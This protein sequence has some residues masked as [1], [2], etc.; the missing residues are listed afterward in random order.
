MLSVL[1]P[2][3]GTFFELL[4]NKFLTWI[5]SGGTKVDESR[6]LGVVVSGKFGYSGRLRAPAMHGVSSYNR[7]YSAMN[8]TYQMTPSITIRIAS[9]PAGSESSKGLA[10][11]QSNRIYC[12]PLENP[13]Q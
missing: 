1:D 10:A 8:W 12:F 4:K 11:I 13:I 9:F 7:N 2:L 3:L 6:K 5:A